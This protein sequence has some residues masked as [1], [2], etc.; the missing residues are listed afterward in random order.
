[1][2]HGDEKEKELLLSVSDSWIRQSPSNAESMHQDGGNLQMVGGR[3]VVDVGKTRHK[4]RVKVW[5]DQT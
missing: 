3:I 1:M 5:R 4:G 2:V